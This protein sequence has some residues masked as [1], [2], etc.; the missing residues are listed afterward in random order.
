MRTLLLLLLTG[1]A[2]TSAA[3]PTPTPTT[4]PAPDDSAAIAR[5]HAFFAAV[6][7]RDTD[8]FHALAS[9]GFF[10][11]EDGYVRPADR[12]SKNWADTNAAGKPRRTR[13]CADEQVRRSGGAVIYVGDC[14]EHDPAHGDRPAQDWQGWNTVVLM[15]ESGAWKVALWQWQKGGIEAERDRWNES[16]RRG[17]GYSTR[18][19]RLLVET[20]AGV[21][22]GTALDVA[23][24]QGRNALYLAEQGWQVTGVDIS[25]EGLRHA[26]Q[27][28]IERGV[29]L[30]AVQANIDEYDFGTARWALVTMIYAGS[31]KGWIERIKPSIAPGGLF[32]LEFFYKDPADTNAGTFVGVGAGELAAAFAGWEILRDEVVEDVA[33]WGQRKTKLVRFVARKP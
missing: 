10:L 20:V 9:T 14:K 1:C 13:T 12:M 26:R 15:P 21:A 27:A 23:T 28:A 8:A 2:T 24:G 16:Y 4:A 18:P 25:D 30:E 29:T 7:G 3:T 17:I 19:N 33:D 6:D 31:D 11:F 5:V 22:P 32:V